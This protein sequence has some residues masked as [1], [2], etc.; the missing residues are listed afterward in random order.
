M[1]G[2]VVVVLGA[3]GRNFAAGMSGGM[4]FVFDRDHTFRSR[5]NTEMVELEPLIDDQD[6]WLVAGLIRDH[7]EYT[8]SAHG[9]R[10][11]EHWDHLA[12]SWIK[13]MPVEYRRALRQRKTTGP[14]PVLAEESAWAR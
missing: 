11:L 13:V 6:V 3:T 10:I 1:T 12:S 2:G 4:A 8:G 5:C 9:A 7:V 14:I